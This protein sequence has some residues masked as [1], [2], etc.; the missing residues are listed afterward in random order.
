[1]GIVSFLVWIFRDRLSPARARKQKNRARAGGRQ[2]QKR[3]SDRRRTHG[4]GERN[5]VCF[6]TDYRTKLNQSSGILCS[7]SLF[8]RARSC[9]PRELSSQKLISASLIEIQEVSNRNLFSYPRPFPSANTQEPE[10]LDLSIA[11]R[12]S[13]FR[14]PNSKS[15]KHLSSRPIA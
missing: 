3:N 14:A 5:F 4:W 11:S 13:W 10:R 15:G 7:L 8:C 1:M 6:R 12:I 2:K 9:L